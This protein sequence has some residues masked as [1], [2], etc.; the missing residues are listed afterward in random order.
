VPVLANSIVNPDAS[1]N[2]VL[3]AERGDELVFPDVSTINVGP[4]GPVGPTDPDVP[5]LPE[6][7]VSPVLPVGPVSP[8]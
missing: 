5:G 1:N 7:P 6:G 3:I 4:V 2:N 8:V